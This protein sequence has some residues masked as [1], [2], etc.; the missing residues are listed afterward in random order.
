MSSSPTSS[1]ITTSGPRPRTTEPAGSPPA[2]MGPGRVQL[3]GVEHALLGVGSE[4]QPAHLEV[5]TTAS[6]AASAA[7]GGGLRMQNSFAAD[8]GWRRSSACRYACAPGLPEPRAMLRSPLV[9]VRGIGAPPPPFLPPQVPYL[10]FVSTDTNSGGGLQGDASQE[11]LE[12]HS[13][14]SSRLAAC[15]MRDFVGME[16]VAAPI[17]AAEAVSLG[18]D[19]SVCVCASRRV[20]GGRSDE[21]RPRRVFVPPHDRQH[22]QAHRAVKLVKSAQAPCTFLPPAVPRLSPRSWSTA[23]A[24]SP[25][26]TR[27]DTEVCTVSALRY[28]RIWHACALNQAA[29]RREVCLGNM[30]HAR[31]ACAVRDAIS[32]HVATHGTVAEP[33]V[34]AAMVAVQLGQLEDAERLYAACGRHDRSTPCTKPVAS[35]RRPSMWRRRRIASTAVDTLHAPRSRTPLALLP[36]PLQRAR[37]RPLRPPA[38]RYAKQLEGRVP[39]CRQASSTRVPIARRSSALYHMPPSRSAMC[40][41]LPR[42]HIAFV[43]GASHDVRQPTCRNCRNISMPLPTPSW[44]AA[45]EFRARVQRAPFPACCTTERSPAVCCAQFKLGPILGVERPFRRRIA[46]L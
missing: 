45:F 6:T 5:A 44:W 43:P 3:L 2:P 22:G 27:S 42:P 10:Y 36:V 30:G 23:P 25:S 13:K 18:A 28:G 4:E 1:R 37:R 34:C 41:V 8:P 20:A 7:Q 16:Q 33:D 12:K 29:R 24:A 32:Q 40:C 17:G 31:G 26:P 38:R 46:V 15:V 19:T 11:H 14:L 39:R 35:G 21:T 9:G